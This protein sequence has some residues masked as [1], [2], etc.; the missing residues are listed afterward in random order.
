MAS[1]GGE[2]DDMAAAARRGGCDRSYDC[3]RSGYGENGATT[4][5]PTVMGMA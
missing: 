4:I 3:S 5:G 1:I 2:G